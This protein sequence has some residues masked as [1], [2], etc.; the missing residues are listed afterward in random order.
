MISLQFNLRNPFSD[1]WECLFNKA[2]ETPFKNKFWE[3]Q[4]DK[5]AD[6]VGFDFRY[7]IRQ[8]HAGLF[9]SLAFFG[10]DVIFNLYDNRHWNYDENRWMFYTE[11]E[12]LH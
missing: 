4:I 3:I 2:G 9:L 8:D 7:T 10:Y 11:E 5:C 12:G 1:R 6:I